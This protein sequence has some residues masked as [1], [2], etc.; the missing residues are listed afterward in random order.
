MSL[1]NDIEVFGQMLHLILPRGWSS[2]LISEAGGTIQ[3]L[4]LSKKEVIGGGQ[5]QLKVCFH[6]DPAD[7][8]Q[9]RLSHRTKKL[10]IV[11]DGSQI[12]PFTSAKVSEGATITLE[13]TKWYSRISV[14]NLDK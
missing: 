5:T 10:P 14:A 8:R 1:K 6:I 9:L 3:V 4:N 12:R 7:L 13:E 2:S 11:V